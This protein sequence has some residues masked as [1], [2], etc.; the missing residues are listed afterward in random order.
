M[1]FIK[2]LN[3]LLAK[4]LQVVEL[5]RLVRLVYVVLLLIDFIK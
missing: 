2:V 4:S 3:E 1:L 5:H